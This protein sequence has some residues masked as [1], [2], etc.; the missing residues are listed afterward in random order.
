MCQKISWVINMIIFKQIL[1]YPLFV[2]V[3]LLGW[4]QTVTWNYDKVIVLSLFYLNPQNMY[5]KR[6]NI[7]NRSISFKNYFE[8]HHIYKWCY[9]RKQS[10]I[11]HYGTLR[12]YISL[13]YIVAILWEIYLTWHQCHVRWLRFHFER[14]LI[15]GLGQ[16]PLIRGGNYER[17]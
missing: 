8:S 15:T 4:S 17:R 3:M 7:Y 12:K 16:Y 9:Y 6:Q 11:K 1:N 2:N 13:C 14:L 5:N 10:S